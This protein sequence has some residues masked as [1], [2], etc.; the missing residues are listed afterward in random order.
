MKLVTTAA[1]MSALCACATVEEVRFDDAPDKT[2][3]EY[4]DEGEACL[5]ADAFPDDLFEAA[6][7]Q[8]FHVGSRLATTVTVP[9]CLSSSC[10]VHRVAQCWVERDGATITVSSLL[11]FDELAAELCT[12]DCG[13]L[14]A[15]CEGE[16]LAAG[17]Y[18]V[19]HGDA[20]VALTVPST[21]AP[22]SGR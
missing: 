20:V 6:E 15:R 14:V 1:A 12:L 19:V 22:C 4:V 21:V 13:R 3:V 9:E 8:L 16:P 11:A 18:Q 10:D 7:P 2:H 17:D 5:Y